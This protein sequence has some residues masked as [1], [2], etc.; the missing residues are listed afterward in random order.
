[1]ERSTV[2]APSTS[3]AG[4]GAGR[5]PSAGRTQCWGRNDRAVSVETTKY[6][7]GSVVCRFRG[8]RSELSIQAGRVGRAVPGATCCTADVAVAQI[9]TDI[10]DGVY[11]GQMIER[12]R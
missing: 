2:D 11:Y 3:S 5:T 7:A 9:G 6:Q 8:R 12:S 10:R 1:M 4:P